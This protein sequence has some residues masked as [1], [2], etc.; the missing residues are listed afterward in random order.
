MSGPRPLF[1]AIGATQE[2]AREQILAIGPDLLGGPP[3][4]L[5]DV[6]TWDGSAWVP[7]PGLGLGEN[8]GLIYRPGGTP[9]FG[10]VTTEADLQAAVAAFAG[11]LTILFDDSF[12]SP[13][14]LTLP[15]T[16]SYAMRW[17]GKHLGTSTTVVLDDGFFLVGP[18]GQVG[19]SYIGSSLN[20]AA[21][22]LV[23]PS[24]LS[25]SATIDEVIIDQSCQLTSG[26][27]FPLFQI[28]NGSTLA[29][30]MSGHLGGNSHPVF[31]LGAGSVLS[32]TVEGFGGISAQILKGS[33]PGSVA[34]YAIASPN[35]Q[36]IS[37]SNPGFAGT[38]TKTLVG[39]AA[40]LAYNDSAVTPPLNATD[41]Q[42]A[43]DALKGLVVSGGGSAAI[44]RGVGAPTA[45]GIFNTW[46][47]L[48][49]WIQAA[50]G[51][52]HVF[53]DSS[54]GALSVDPGL[55]TF[56]P[57]VEFIGSPVGPLTDVT[58]NESRFRNV[59]RWSRINFIELNVTTVPFG[60]FP[61]TIEFNDCAV[62]M[63]G[64]AQPF[65]RTVTSAMDVTFRHMAVFPTTQLMFDMQPSAPACTVRLYDGT[66]VALNSFSSAIGTTLTLV[67]DSSSVYLDQFYVF[68]TLIRQLENPVYIPGN[69][70]DWTSPAPTTVFEALDRLA[71][72]FV[73]SS[74]G[75]P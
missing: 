75:K 61:E 37:L 52:K 58:L 12:V 55:W 7:M 2:S 33:D 25:V 60:N 47:S 63:S 22:G 9:T 10:V 49:A 42:A 20:L 43:L 38:V 41:V 21:Q 64:G 19:I 14:H 17:E 16:V 30:F 34:G 54:Y 45:P 18:S 71:A 26:G 74:L 8:G 32:I 67:Q 65:I 5:G 73:A 51:S 59:W 15:W 6:L 13:I 31:G 69:A 56:T 4:T 36:A 11:P 50:P 23:G 1:A 72:K 28:A 53:L 40:Y 46:A 62:I 3:P 48:F 57:P 24:P 66:T 29:L 44:W 70:S 68:G 35:V 27:T 39:Q